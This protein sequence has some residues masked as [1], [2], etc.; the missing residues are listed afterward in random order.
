MNPNN[1]LQKA[2]EDTYFEGGKDYQYGGYVPPVP[3]ITPSSTPGSVSPTPTPTQTKTPSPT[4]TITPT[5][6]DGRTCRTYTIANNGFGSSVFNWTECDGSFSS[7]TLSFGASTTICAKNGS[8]SQNGLGIITDIGT[9]P[10]PT[11]TPTSTT[12]PTSTPQYDLYDAENCCSPFDT[13]TIGLLSGTIYNQDAGVEYAGSKYYIIGNGSG[14]PVVLSSSTIDN[15]CSTISCPSPT[16]TTSPFSSPTPTPSITPT[17]SLTPSIT[18]TN[19]PTISVSPTQTPT[20]SPTQSPTGTPTQTPTN[21]KTPTPTPTPTST[22]TPTPTI[23]PTNTRTPTPTPTCTGCSRLYQVF[24]NSYTLT[25]VY[26]YTA[27]NCQQITNKQIPPRTTHN[28]YCKIY[29]PCVGGNYP[30]T[31]ANSFLT[32]TLMPGCYA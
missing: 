23:T 18:P 9:C 31:T 7:T 28:V 20:N 17:I 19:T 10:L 16:P 6:T 32:I 12:T 15:I 21:T 8:V 27:T 13:I 3:F 26:R 11:P 30:P 14:V 24:N 1:P 25:G 29:C 4:P 2:L 5:S 22:Q